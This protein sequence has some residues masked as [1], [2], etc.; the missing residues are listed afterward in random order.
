MNSDSKHKANNSSKD[1]TEVYSKSRI[2]WSKS[3]DDVWND[4]FENAE[5]AEDPKIIPIKRKPVFLYVAAAFT[6][7]IGLASFMKFY[8]KTVVCPS[9]QHL[10]AML[11][12]GSTVDLNANSQLKFHP[13]WWFVS[14]EL[15]FE[16]EAFFKVKK[17]KKFEVQSFYGNTSVL[18][19]SFNIYSRES[20]YEVTCVTGKVQVESVNNKQAVVLKPNY[21][22]TINKGGQIFVN[23]EISV[24]HSIAWIK[25]DLVFTSEP[26]ELVFKELERQYNIDITL[27]DNLNINYTGNFA[28]P[29]NVDE[30]LQLICQPLGI[31]FEKRNNKN[32]IIMRIKD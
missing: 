32:Y 2:P 12:D 14:R 13:Y 6:L 20:V 9:G 15:S 1:V 22:A 7:L 23:K 3:K 30:A 4:F 10:T 29:A 26:L 31:K 11:P 16:G 24:D 18:G 17:G 8:S 21:Q 27:P 25:N 5:P 19:T 28:Q